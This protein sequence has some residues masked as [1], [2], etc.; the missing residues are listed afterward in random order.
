MCA[1]HWRKE[2]PPATTVGE[3][4]PEDLGGRIVIRTGD[5]IGTV[6][7]TLLAAF[8]H[9]TLVHFSC[10]QVQGKKLLTLRNDTEAIVVDDLRPDVH[11]NN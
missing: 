1:Q 4:S 2:D 8:P 10:V 5:F 7:G 6:Y 11:R 3:L 9:P